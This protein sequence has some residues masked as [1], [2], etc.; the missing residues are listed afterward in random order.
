MGSI[1]TRDNKIMDSYVIV[2]RQH[3]CKQLLT[4]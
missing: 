3:T 4:C 2:G 1:R